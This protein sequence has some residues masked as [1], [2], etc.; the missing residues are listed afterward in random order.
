MANNWDIRKTDNGNH[1]WTVNGA[2]GSRDIE[3]EYEYE[4]GTMSSST[5]TGLVFLSKGDLEK[6]LKAIAREDD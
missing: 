3:L 2:C 6:M 5:A 4:C 1:E